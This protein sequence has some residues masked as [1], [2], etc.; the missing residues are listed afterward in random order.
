MRALRRG[1]G[2]IPTLAAALALALT[3][4]A[5]KW[6]FDRAA[7]KRSLEADY[8]ARQAAPAVRIADGAEHADELRY[9]RVEAT[10]EFLA[11]HAIYLDNRVRDGVAGFEIVMPLRLAHGGRPVLVNRG[12]V[13]QGVRRTELPRVETTTGTVTVVGTV[14]VPGETVYELSDTTVEGRIWQNLVLSRYRDAT[15]LR[16]ADYVILQ[17][18]DA[19]DGLLREWAVPGFGI[20]THL[21]YAVQWLLFASLVVFFYVYYGFI[22]KKSRGRA[23]TPQ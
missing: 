12:W 6:Q 11:E 20:E 3:L 10:G 15:G 5:A 23:G 16:V 2:M 9:R 18:N 21:T 7:Y 17:E 13:R 14:A 1:P 19:A 22:R 8:R 4:S